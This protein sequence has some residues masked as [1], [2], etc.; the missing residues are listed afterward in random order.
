MH[1]P[2][3]KGLSESQKQKIVQLV[4][5]DGM[6]AKAASKVV[7]CSPSTARLIIQQYDD[8]RHP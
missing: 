8:L 4:K 3:H 2:K 6:T 7:G 1:L 5:Q